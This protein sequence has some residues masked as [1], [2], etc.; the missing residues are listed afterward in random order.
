MVDCR[1]EGVA[2]RLD[3]FD[4]EAYTLALMNTVWIL[5]CDSARARFFEIYDGDSSWHLV[6]EAS[7]D[8]SM[9][10]AADLVSDKSGSRSSEGR[11]VH[12]DALAPASSPK[13]VEKAHFAHTLG[14]ILDQ[15][16]RSARFRRWVL[17]T[18][19]HFAGLLKKELT[20][21]LTK[22]LMTIVDKDM[23]HLDARDLADKLRAVVRIPVDERDR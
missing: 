3:V 13:N 14:T 11:S 15:A 18:P 8:E 12:H 23:N 4:D 2:R 5:V 22:H 16:M 10:K 20:P 1:T 17:V 7:H 9:S 21:E 19:P 6:H